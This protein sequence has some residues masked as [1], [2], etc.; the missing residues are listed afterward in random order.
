MI[1]RLWRARCTPDNAD[2]Y[3]ELLR[4]QILPEL[5]RVAG[6]RGAYVLRR[7]GDDHVEFLVI[8]LFDSLSVIRAFAGDNYQAAVVPASARELLASFDETAEHFEVRATPY[9]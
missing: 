3:E 9:E 5:D 7:E 4:T 2:S 6:C 1:S 8:H